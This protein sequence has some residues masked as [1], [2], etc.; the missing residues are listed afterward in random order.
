MANMPY[1]FP[2]NPHFCAMN[3]LNMQKRSTQILYQYLS[4]KVVRLTGLEPVP[5]RTR[6]SNVRVCL[7]RHNR[8]S[9]DIIIPARG[10]LVKYLIAL[11]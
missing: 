1:F 2:F 11:N 7:F 4:T 8:V 9:T 5:S 10:G 3:P 6:P